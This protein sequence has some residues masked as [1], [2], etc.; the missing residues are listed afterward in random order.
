MDGGLI[1]IEACINNSTGNFVLDT[2]AEGLVLNSKYYTGTIDESRK[3]YGIAGRGT[4][5]GV[6]R[7]NKLLVEA[8]EFRNITADVVNLS[9]IE[10]RKS[11]KISGLIGYNLLKDFEIM[12]NYRERFLYL[13]ALDKYGNISGYSPFQKDKVD[14]LDF[15]MGNFIP[16]I[17][18][19]VNGVKKRF[20]LDS[21]AEVNLLDLKRSKDVRSEF[22]PIRTIR[23]TGSDNK[24]TEVIA[25]RMKKVV[26]LEKYKCAP[27]ATVLV[28]M[29]N[30][31]KIY[32]TRLD[33]I[34]G[35]EFLGP[36]RISINY[37][38]QRLYLHALNV[39]LP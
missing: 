18:V 23:I 34:L 16:V 3:F 4:G 17:E 39:L 32:N 35:Y 29:E 13:S 19:E 6:T 20:G 7:K 27:M 24:E 21:G 30:L 28:N 15:V 25:G 10:D 11:I 9:S 12:I 38:K 37:K 8:L 22:A 33:G 36:W 5:L 14:S 2:G 26:L 1:I 31:D